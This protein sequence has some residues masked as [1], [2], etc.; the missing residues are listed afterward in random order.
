[1]VIAYQG[2]VAQEAI[3]AGG[4]IAQGRR[5]IGVL[6]VTSADRLNA[7]WTAAQRARSNGVQSAQS[8]IETLLGDLPRNC[9][10][11]TVIDGHPAT[12]SWLGAVHGHQTIPHGVEHFGQT[13]NITDLYRHFRIDADALIQSASELSQG[14]K[15]PCVAIA[16]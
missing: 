5:D 2:A 15:I 8:H 1:M 7:G 12:L 3:K 14:R 6:A 10:I 16:G 13:G 11:I 4:Y 9:I